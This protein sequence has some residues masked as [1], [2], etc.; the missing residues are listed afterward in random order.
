MA[1]RSK[2]TVGLDGM[3]KSE[4][5]PSG[6]GSRPSEEAARRRE[7]RDRRRRMK[8]WHEARFGMLVVYGLYSPP[9]VL[10]AEDMYWGRISVKD[11][12]KLA[13]EF[14]PRK[15]AARLWADLADY[16]PVATDGG[17]GDPPMMPT[18]IRMTWPAIK[19]VQKASRLHLRLSQMSTTHKFKDSAFS[20][21]RNL[22]AGM[23]PPVQVDAT[24]GRVTPAGERR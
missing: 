11:C 15:D 22:P 10:G 5:T 20:F 8:W 19:G 13:R 2:R 7:E 17:E 23:P 3:Q 24:Y 9:R 21:A 6:K 18:S 4:G 14:K 1:K 12:E 16:A